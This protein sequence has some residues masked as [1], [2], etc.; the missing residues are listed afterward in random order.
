MI[1]QTF[2]AKN[3]QEIFDLQNR[4]GSDIERKFKAIFNQSIEIRKEIRNTT[5]EIRESNNKEHLKALYDLRDELKAR[6]NLSTLETLEQVSINVNNPSH[7]VN[8]QEGGMYGKQ[9]YKL[10]NTSE[11]FFLSKQLQQNIYRN[12]KIRQASRFEVLSQLIILLEDNFPKVVIRTDI[13]SFYESIPQKK[14]ISKIKDDNLLSIKS[15]SFI[16]KILEGYNKITKQQDNDE[17]FGLP[18]G[19]GISAYLSELFM[20]S[21]D[22]EIKD[23]ADVTFYARYVDDIVVVFTPQKVVKEQAKIYRHSV[24]ECITKHNLSVNISKT[25]SFNLIGDLSA[26][27]IDATPPRIMNFLGYDIGS[28]KKIKTQINE[29]DKAHYTLSLSMTCKKKNKY[30]ERIELAYTEFNN[31]KSHNR[32]RAFK[33]LLARMQFL[34]SNTRLRNNKSKVFTGIYYSNPFLQNSVSLDEIQ[35]FNVDKIQ[36]NDFTS[37]EKDMLLK[38]DFKI[39]FLKKRFICF[40]L[41]NKTYKNHNS[42]L[43]EEPN[44]GILQFGLSEITKI[45][46]NA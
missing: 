38:C 2:S 29:A 8:I 5:K 17:Q 13:N 1:D 12:Y 27:D 28:T 40:P 46:K 3:F 7:T 20:R 42:K 44:N 15:Q 14:L 33:M 32:K 36:D 11:I 24:E 18:R 45:W 4:K 25:D 10:E 22:N 23:L 35:S 9:S 19:V 16:E 30:K 39:G 21:I 37:K 41:A 43:K 26:I 6:R 34:S 31:K